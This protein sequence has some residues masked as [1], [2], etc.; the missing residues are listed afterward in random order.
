MRGLHGRESVFAPSDLVYLSPD[1][2]E[3]LQQFDKT[4]VYV[5]GGFVDRSVNKVG[6]LH[7]CMKS[8]S[9]CDEGVGTGDSRCPL[10]D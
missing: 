10:A 1:G 4:K 7:A 9:E 8:E 6:F 3:S 5:I 2:S